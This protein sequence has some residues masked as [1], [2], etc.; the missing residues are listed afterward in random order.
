MIQKLKP[1]LDNLVTAFSAACQLGI[2]YPTIKKW[3]H[4]KQIWA[5]RV[6][7]VWLV[8]L[9]E[10]RAVQRQR[11]EWRL[12]KRHTDGDGYCW[13]TVDEA[14]R[15]VGLSPTTIRSWVACGT[16]RAIKVG[17]RRVV[18]LRDVLLRAFGHRA[19]EAMK[20]SESNGTEKQES[21]RDT[22]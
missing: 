1:D 10:V 17:S 18:W 14:S 21:D 11:L 5:K 3:I 7:N 22:D 6:G 13:V 2:P 8:D 20:T 19:L 16:V 4:R 9:T 12:K 15:I